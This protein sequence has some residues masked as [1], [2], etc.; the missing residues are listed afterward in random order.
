MKILN[1]TFHAW[2]H[3]QHF[4]EDFIVLANIFQHNKYHYCSH[5]AMQ[6]IDC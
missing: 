2:W 6:N 4:W 5:I 3:K 1:N